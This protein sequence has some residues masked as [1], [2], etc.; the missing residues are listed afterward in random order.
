MERQSQPPQPA[1]I[2]A[3][4]GWLFIGLL[5]FFGILRPSPSSTARRIFQL[6]LSLS[7]SAACSLFVG[8][9]FWWRKEAVT[10]QESSHSATFVNSV[11]LTS[12]PCFPTL[13][14]SVL[15]FFW[16]GPASHFTESLQMV[17]GVDW[18]V[19]LAYTL[20]AI[21]RR[22]PR[23]PDRAEQHITLY[24][25]VYVVA[26][27]IAYWQTNAFLV[28]LCW[29]FV[30]AD[31]LSR[32]ATT[33]HLN[34]S[35][36]W[37]GKL[38]AA[39]ALL[40]LLR[41]NTY[42]CD[43]RI[44]HELPSTSSQSH[45]Q[46]ASSTQAQTCGG[47]GEC[48][49]TSCLSTEKT[50]WWQTSSQECWSRG[51]C[52]EGRKLHSLKHGDGRLSKISHNGSLHGTWRNGFIQH[53]TI[54]ALGE[55]QLSS[56]WFCGQCITGHCPP[57]SKR[58]VPASRKRKSKLLLATWTG[59]DVTQW[60]ADIG[61]S[62]YTDGFQQHNITGK[63]I[64][65]PQFY[66]EEYLMMLGVK[67][68][69][70][71]RLV[72]AV[73]RL[74]GAYHTHQKELQALLRTMSVNACTVSGECHFFGNVYPQIRHSLLLSVG[75]PAKSWIL[76][77]VWH[78]MDMLERMDWES[79]AAHTLIQGRSQPNPQLELLKTWS[80]NFHQT[81][82]SGLLGEDEVLTA[83][84]VDA[85]VLHCF[86]QHFDGHT[87]TG[88][89]LDRYFLLLMDLD[90]NFAV[91]FSEYVLFMQAHTHFY[92]LVRR[93]KQQLL[94]AQ[95]WPTTGSLFKERILFHAVRLA[96]EQMILGDRSCHCS[97]LPAPSKL[98]QELA[99]SDAFAKRADPKNY[100]GYDPHLES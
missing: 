55:E 14:C 57:N 53:A 8:I 92:Q 2:T 22:T 88:R 31:L 7:V 98:H 23:T 70:S 6:L 80:E 21:T 3:G 89:N 25:W 11:Y 1:K 77:S 9:A 82:P 27:A 41:L 24:S 67:A 93:S 46:L 75:M 30:L 4:E 33:L 15:V 66:D 42:H 29:D 50:F 61:M 5:T 10:G 60:L 87:W 44:V 96:R 64:L 74:I 20:Y 71:V 85:M 51:L 78:A 56:K 43:H 79:H 72:S 90:G 58:T 12:L 17:G 52:F 65:Q 35:E 16:D 39:S 86:M 76:E 49:E 19:W 91:D 73:L 32:L 47:L 45:L 97:K 40:A 63:E 54:S 37:Q 94:L 13:L 95:L 26:P 83:L 38:L 84:G 100:Y 48:S 28:T 34:R 99:W 68:G 36:N 81:W 18:R 59:D 69:D 62:E